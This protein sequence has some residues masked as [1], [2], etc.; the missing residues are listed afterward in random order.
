M[1]IRNRIEYRGLFP[2]VA[3]KNIGPALKEGNRATVF[4]WHEHFLPLHFETFARQKYGYRQRTRAYIRRKQGTIGANRDLVKTGNLMRNAKQ[5]IKVTGTSKGARG[6]MQGT[7]VANLRRG[8]GPDM[9]AEM[10]RTLPS[11]EKTL[12]NFHENKVRSRLESIQARK[13]RRF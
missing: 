2:E 13:T 12:A 1:V 10:L 5:S 4:N 9:R 11:E 3:A 6:T 7:Q 8:D